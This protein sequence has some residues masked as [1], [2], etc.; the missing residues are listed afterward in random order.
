MRLTQGRLPGGLPWEEVSLRSSEFLLPSANVVISV[1][2]CVYVCVFIGCL[3]V[4]VS[5]RACAEC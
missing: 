4:C 5:Q 1:C 2:V 3:C